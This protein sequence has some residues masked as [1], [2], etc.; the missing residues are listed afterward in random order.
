VFAG[1]EIW[2]GSDSNGK[3]V[4]EFTAVVAP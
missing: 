2:T 4:Q 1:F 3:S